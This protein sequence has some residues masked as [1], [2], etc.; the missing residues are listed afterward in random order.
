MSKKISVCFWSIFNRND[1]QGIENSSQ[2][3]PPVTKELLKKIEANQGNLYIYAN[4][5]PN[6]AE[7][8]G[9]EPEFQKGLVLAMME[10][11]L[12]K[13]DMPYFEVAI[14]RPYGDIHL[15]QRIFQHEGWEELLIKKLSGR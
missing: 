14:E 7:V 2:P 9:R 4:E 1:N 11:R 6:K 8:E 3:S 5:G 12:N 15:N 10:E 13:E